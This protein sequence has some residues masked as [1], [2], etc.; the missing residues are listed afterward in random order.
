MVVS[1]IDMRMD[2][3]TGENPQNNAKTTHKTMRKTM[4]KQFKNKLKPI[5]PLI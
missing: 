2:L 1:R 4:R 5:G 3:V